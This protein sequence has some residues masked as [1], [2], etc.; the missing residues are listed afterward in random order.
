MK[1]QISRQTERG[2]RPG[3]ALA[4]IQPTA[5]PT[6][7]KGRILTAEER[8]SRRI[9]ALRTLEAMLL[10]YAN[11]LQSPNENVLGSASGVIAEALETFEELELLELMGDRDAAREAPGSGV[12][13]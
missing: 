13:G 7:H 12:E 5:A 9:D 4:R 2:D 11:S 1:S 8:Y 6:Q 3:V 10:Q